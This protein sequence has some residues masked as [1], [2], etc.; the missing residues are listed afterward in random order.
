MRRQLP[1]IFVK[2]VEMLKKQHDMTTL[3]ELKE[4]A[5]M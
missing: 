3:D 4:L 5:V 2:F 1:E